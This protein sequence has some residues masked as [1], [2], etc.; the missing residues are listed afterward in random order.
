MFRNSPEQ[1]GW[2]MT[3]AD[4]GH[5]QVPAAVCQ[6]CF[7]MSDLLSQKKRGICK[8]TTQQNNNDLIIR[9]ERDLLLIK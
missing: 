6:R 7:F 3:T 5:S 4:W 9:A 2:L 1:I 8:N